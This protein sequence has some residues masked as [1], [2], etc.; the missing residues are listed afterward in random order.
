MRRKQLQHAPL[1]AQARQ[2]VLLEHH[3]VAAKVGEPKQ[4]RHRPRPAL[5][6]G[7]LGVYKQQLARAQRTGHPSAAGG[8]RPQGVVGK[9]VGGGKG[10][11]ADPLL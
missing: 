2:K 1:G 7:G 11:P 9:Y 6:A 8:Q 4:K 10:A 3:L 5:Q